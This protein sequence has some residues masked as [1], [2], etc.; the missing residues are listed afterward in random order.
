MLYVQ[1]YRLSG[2][3]SHCVCVC[4]YKYIYIYTRFIYVIDSCVSAQPSRKLW[5]II[6]TGYTITFIDG[7]RDR[8]GKVDYHIN[9]SHSGQYVFIYIYA[10]LDFT[11]IKCARYYIILLDFEFQDNHIF[12]LFY[13]HARNYPEIQWFKKSHR[14]LSQFSGLMGLSWEIL[15]WDLSCSCHQVVSGTGVI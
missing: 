1:F 9:N 4:A 15:T 13:H 2:S 11:Q 14:N 5:K 7:C 12:W 3:K 8:D 10:I 6:L